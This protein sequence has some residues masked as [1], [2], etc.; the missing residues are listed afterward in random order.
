MMSLLPDPDISAPAQAPETREAL[1][2]W[3]QGKVNI[4]D[5]LARLE[6]ERNAARED[7]RK[8]SAENWLGQLENANQQMIRA[9]QRAASL[10]KAL[11]EARKERNAARE[12]ADNLEDQRDLAMR[13]IKRLETELATA[14]AEASKWEKL[15]DE[16]YFV[17]FSEQ[18]R[19]SYQELETIPECAERLIRERNALRA[20]S[21]E[22]ESALSYSA[23]GQALLSKFLQATKDRD[24][25]REKYCQLLTENMLEVQ[26]LNKALDAARATIRAVLDENRH[27]ADGKNCTLASLKALVPDWK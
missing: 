9:E 19:D 17:L 11:D 2:R 1:E 13:T 22:L 4:G 23:E 10:G 15:Y 21:R 27:L 5:E 6:T 25:A 8:A 24:E 3:R 7:A 20:R 26:R 12:D 16:V 18:D 14:R